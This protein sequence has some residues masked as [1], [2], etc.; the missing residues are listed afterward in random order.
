[1]SGF[2]SG[3]IAV[4]LLRERRTLN[5][6]NWMYMSTRKYAVSFEVLQVSIG[7]TIRVVILEDTATMIS[8]GVNQSLNQ[9]AA[10][11]LK[12]TLVHCGVQY[13]WPCQL[14]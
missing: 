11:L 13:V 3:I 2:R 7:G 1:M 8:A 5:L 9:L 4:Y 12:P 6:M 14:H 10:G